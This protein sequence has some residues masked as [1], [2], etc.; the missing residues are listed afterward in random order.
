M[1]R[2]LSTL[3]SSRTSQSKKTSMK[4]LLL[5]LAIVCCC[6][7]GAK[8]LSAPKNKNNPTSETQSRFPL[9]NRRQL[10][11]LPLGI[12]GTYG[13]GRLVY[14]A[15][16]VR[17]I[18]Y[19][20][21]HER[22]VEATIRRALIA[23]VPANSSIS[24]N[25]PLRVLEVGIGTDCRLL[26]RGLY[27]SAFRDLIHENK[28]I[29]Q[30]D[31]TG[32]DIILP[33]DDIVTGTRRQLD[34]LGADKSPQINLQV[35]SGSI[36]DG[37]SFA[38]GYFDSIVCCLVLCSV[39]DQMRALQEMKRLL[40]PDGGTLGYIEHVAVDEQE[41]SKFLE[42]QQKILDPLQQAVAH[43]CHLHRY[44]EQA[45]ETT[46]GSQAGE[47]HKSSERLQ[48]ERFIVDSMWPVSCQC[49][50]VVQRTL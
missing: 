26:R 2:L 49:C 42:A 38:D 11:K 23:S 9:L 45:I 27:N 15:L 21:T 47:T 6:P 28:G 10:W 7:E 22:R 44:T 5:I 16:S 43:N 36:T 50:G 14:N 46:F 18:K 40:R 17:D 32:V 24:R 29:E 48:H 41:S 35:T 13:Y 1:R 8:A 39:T 30:I 19:P 34:K 12:V 31:L 4:R 20:E 37:L 25:R 3:H 33:N